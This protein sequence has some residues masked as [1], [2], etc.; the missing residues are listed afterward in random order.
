MN[1]IY[2]WLEFFREWRWGFAGAFFFMLIKG[3]LSIRNKSLEK[4]AEL[5]KSKNILENEKNEYQKNI[6][7]LMEEI[8][9]LLVRGNNLNPD[10]VTNWRIDCIAVITRFFG[11]NSQELLILNKTIPDSSLEI[12]LTSRRLANMKGK[13]LRQLPPLQ[14]D[15]VD[16]DLAFLEWIADRVFQLRFPYKL[17]NN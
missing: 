8:T 1:G 4:I 11:K 16:F 17:R 15:S 10:E 7:L 14:A 9:N 6:N 12:R 3:H 5:N 2:A 13:L